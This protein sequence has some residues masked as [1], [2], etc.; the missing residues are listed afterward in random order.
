MR[1][2]NLPPWALAY[3]QQNNAVR[4]PPTCRGPEGLGAKRV[5]TMEDFDSLMRR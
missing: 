5:R 2:I 4:A 1:R 3:A